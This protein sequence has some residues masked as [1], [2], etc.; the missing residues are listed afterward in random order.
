MPQIRLK[1]QSPDY[2][3]PAKM[4]QRGAPR[5][6]DMPGCTRPGEHRAPKNRALTDYHWFCLDHVQEY[7]TA[8]DFF[9]GMADRDIER[10]ILAS[11]YGDRPTWRSD[12]Y[13]G[14]EV[15]VKERVRAFGILW[16]RRRRQIPLPGP[17]PP[18]TKPWPRWAWPTQSR[19]RL[20]K[21]ATV[22][23]SNNTTPIITS[24]PPTPRA[25]IG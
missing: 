14:L 13:R 10:H 17:K 12:D 2:D 15:T 23:W 3:A 4:S 22:N 24:A 20:L 16:M 25:K 18:R 8:W 11:F 19:S 21:S 6:C 9:A 7:N 5:Y 1:P